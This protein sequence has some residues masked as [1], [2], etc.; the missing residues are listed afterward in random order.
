[1]RRVLETCYTGLTFLAV[2]LGL[3]LGV[4]FLV[5]VIAGGDTGVSLSAFAGDLM[6]WCIAVAAM[7]VLVGIVHMYLSGEHA[8]TVTGGGAADSHDD[9]PAGPDAVR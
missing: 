8:L 9:E 7:A 5:A 4:V 6:S 1:M 2:L 3:G